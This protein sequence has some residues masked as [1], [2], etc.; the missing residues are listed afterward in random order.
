M[1]VADYGYGLIRKITPIGVVT[2]LAGS[3]TRGHADGRGSAASFA[4]PQGIA[5]DSAG[6]VY[7]AELLNNKI[8]KIT[9][10]GVV[11]TLA[12]S[13]SQGYADGPGAVASFKLPFGLAV[14]SSGNVYVADTGNALIR[15]ISPDGEVTTFAGTENRGG[16]VDGPRTSVSFG[17]PEGIAVDSA[18]NFYIADYY[19]N[20]IRKISADG[21]VTTLAGTGLSGHADG[22]ASA[23]SFALPSGVAVD[24][25]GNLYVADSG[26]NSIRRIQ[27]S[28]LVPPA[29][30]PAQKQ[31][32]SAGDMIFVQGGT[33]TMGSPASEAGR[34]SDELQHQVTVANFQIGKYD[35]TQGLYESVMGANPSHF[36]GD[37]SLPVE[38]LTW[39][40][41]V[42]FCDTL[43][44]LNGL[45]EAYTID[46]KNV[47]ANW[48]ANGYRLPTEAEWE[49]AAR[50]GQ[51]GISEYHQYAGSDNVDQVG[52][53]SG[54]SGKMTHPVGQKAPNALGLFD[55]SGN[56]L[57]W[58]WDV[59][60]DYSGG[61]QTHPTGAQPSCWGVYRG[62]GWINAARF[63]R[64]AYRGRTNPGSQMPI[65]GFRLVRN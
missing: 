39:Y 33:F 61:A 42:A 5:V 6:N 9:P 49:Y 44:D 40:D 1:Y 62:G 46:G 65:L 32:L 36:K 31:S 20:R 8:R 19:S 63:L 30:V 4:G 15:K 54:N 3:G 13:G 12:G 35:V 24:S 56:V 55:M 50:G 11:T 59:Y 60:A 57:Q 21:I 47:T 18:G 58:C 10:D 17:H 45:Q 53:Y 23:A 26:N 28:S 48:E 52:W 14:D 51:K 16:Q 22:P 43:S 37:P 34:G 38:S 7:V 25:F 2:T 41:A 27:L 29:A 64:V